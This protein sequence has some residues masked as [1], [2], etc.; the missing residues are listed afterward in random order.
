M[1]L[2]RKIPKYRVFFSLL[3]QNIYERFYDI[4]IL[5]GRWNSLCGSTR[6]ANTPCSWASEGRKRCEIFRK[7]QRALWLRRRF[8]ECGGSNWKDIRE[9]SLQLFQQNPLSQRSLC[10]PQ[11]LP[12]NVEGCVLS[13]SQFPSLTYLL[14]WYPCYWRREWVQD[15]KECASALSH[16][17]GWRP[18][19]QRSVLRSVCPCRIYSKLSDVCERQEEVI[20]GPCWHVTQYSFCLA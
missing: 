5:V 2:F 19:P 16:L 3:Y 13:L 20:A 6:A 8:G 10:F 15:H 12:G 17:F 7:D 18:R 14:V 11:C 4:K 1:R 9:A